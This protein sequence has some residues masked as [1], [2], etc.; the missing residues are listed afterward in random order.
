MSEPVT[1]R[2]TEEHDHTRLDKFLVAQYPSESRATI[3]KW[4][5][6]GC[7]L[8]N[9]TQASKHYS[10][11]VNDV[12]VIHDRNNTPPQQHKV[13]PQHQTPLQHGPLPP[14]DIIYEDDDLLV[15]HKPIGV[16]VHA[17][18]KT[19]Q[20]TVV[21]MV[22][23]HAP[24]I[25]AV[26]DDPIR[27]GIVHR[28][29]REVSGVMVIAKTMQA[30]EHLKEQFQHRTVQKEYRAIVHGVPSKGAD[31]LKFKIAHSKRKNG[32]MAARPEHE[33]GKEAWTEYH[34]LQTRNN[35]Y[36]VLAVII[37]TGRTHQIRAHL[38][39]IDHP[40]VGDT[41]YESKHYASTRTYPRLFLHAYRLT[42]RHPQT[43]QVIS[44]EA[45]LPQEF[46]KFLQ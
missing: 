21:D 35:R 22:R 36:A 33:E 44:F 18:G 6:S 38:A 3:Q 1:V 14:L 46:E 27:P 24:A 32:K 43:E 29:D 28:L 2:V 5:E 19:P 16:L 15:I 13:V 31:V 17:D 40:I 9:G 41:L 30:F 23:L 34:V 26:G 4:I 7:V 12:I 20:H 8:V 37:K 45:P 11:D 10:L 25:A 42:V 39:A